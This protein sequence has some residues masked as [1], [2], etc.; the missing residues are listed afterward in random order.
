MRTKLLVKSACVLVTTG[1][2]FIT[3]YTTAEACTTVLVGKDASKDGSTMIARNED[4][5]TAWTKH[6]FV[7]EANKNK[8][9][10]VSEG[11]GFS[12]NLPKKQL[13]YTATPEWDVSE[14]LY[15][16]AGINSN[17]IAMSGTES[18]TAKENVLELDPLVEKGIAEDAIVT[19]VLPYINSAKEGIERLG[20]IVEDKGAAETNGI[21]FSDN[22]DIWYMEILTGHHWVATRVPDDSYAVIA[23]TISIQEF[24]WDDSANFLYSKNLQEF[25]SDNKLTDD[26]KNI[27]IRETF[28][29]T[30]DDAQYNTPRIWYGQKMLT[31]SDKKIDDTDFKLFVKADE[32]ITTQ[33]IAGILGSHYNNTDYDT[34]GEKESDKYRP[35]SVPNTM[36]SHILQIRNNVPDEISAIHW[37]ALGVPDTSNYIPFYSGITETPKEYQIGTDEPDE[38]S[39]Y[40]TYRTTNALTNPYHDEFKTEIIAPVQ[41][42]VWDHMTE[43]VEKIDKEAGKMAEKNPKKLDSYLN[44]KTKELSDYSLKEYKQV[45]RNLIKKM[46]EKTNVRHNEEL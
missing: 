4:M 2:L 19:V 30:K 1:L 39:A 26:L 8:A 14:G 7:R 42:K 13:K 24:D 35:I 32:P 29:D 17:N 21:I 15:E 5:G 20:K 18:T 41:E 40:W 11:N 25:V 33:A 3:S 28:A 44:K 6:F 38:K 34:F 12:I 22:N 16:E 27:S 9:K 45:N 46:T 31:E 37:L 23:N 36:E 43:A 10:F